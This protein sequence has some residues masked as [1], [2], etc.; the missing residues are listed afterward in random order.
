MDLIAESLHS[1]YT[2]VQLAS[3]KALWRIGTEESLGL[4]RNTLADSSATHSDRVR[5]AAAEALA[6]RHDLSALPLMKALVAECHDDRLHEGLT[7]ALSLLKRTLLD[8]PTMSMIGD[9]VLLHFLLEDV[10]DIS[11]SARRADIPYHLPK[12][13]WELFCQSLQMAEKTSG[14]GMWSPRLTLHLVLVDGRDVVLTTDCLSN[15]FMYRGNGRL[16]EHHTLAVA[17]EEL[18]EFLKQRIPPEALPERCREIF[19]G[20]EQQTN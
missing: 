18:R 9:H 12:E 5:I 7:R 10:E 11:V 19:E 3:V 6:D 16:L 20:D 8:Q 15:R 17:S 13:D 4:L 14:G 1:E 2:D